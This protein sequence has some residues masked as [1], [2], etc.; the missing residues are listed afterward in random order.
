[1][2][3]GSI[4]YPFAQALQVMMQK[5]QQE[6]AQKNAPLDNLTGALQTLATGYYNKKAKEKELAGETARDTN[7]ITA[8]GYV[9][10][11]LGFTTPSTDG[12]SAGQPYY[13]KISELVG[14]KLPSNVQT[15]PVEDENK[16]V[17]RK[18]NQAKLEDLQWTAGLRKELTSLGEPAFKQKYGDAV[19]QSIKALPPF[20]M[21]DLLGAF[22]YS[23]MGAPATGSGFNPSSGTIKVKRKSDGATGSISASEF[24]PAI[25]ERQ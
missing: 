15:M 7:K 2:S 22:G 11:K 16:A 21:M 8:E 18:L 12:T 6:Q 25:Y 3:Y 17:Q 23:G 10:N 4:D 9:N 5:R 1:M 20:N 13:P 19:L 24:D 14:G